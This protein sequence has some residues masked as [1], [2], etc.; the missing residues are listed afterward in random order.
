LTCIRPG[1]RSSSIPDCATPLAARVG[2]HRRHIPSCSPSRPAVR[3][4][5]RLIRRLRHRTPHPP[6]P[7]PFAH[8]LRVPHSPLA[9]ILLCLTGGS[10]QSLLASVGSRPGGGRRSIV[11]KRPTMRRGRVE[12]KRIENK[13]N[14]QV[15]FAKHRNGLLKKAYESLSSS[16][17]TAA[18][19][20]SSAA[21]RGIYTAAC[22][23]AWGMYELTLAQLEV[24]YHSGSGSGNGCVA[25]G[26]SF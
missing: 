2:H 10:E 24:P 18:S 20:T 26:S 25:A 13:I 19:S 16:S 6:S 8:L 3:H 23:R 7:L 12:L 5:H 9:L 17:P 22:T 21:T 1:I 14:Q 11:R 15:T 4:C